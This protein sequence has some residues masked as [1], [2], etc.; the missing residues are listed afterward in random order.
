MPKNML[1]MSSGGG[2]MAKLIG[3]VIALVVVMLVVKNPAGA[4]HLVTSLVN[5]L[6]AFVGAL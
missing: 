2:A 3:G 1:P 5:G 6:V 4:A